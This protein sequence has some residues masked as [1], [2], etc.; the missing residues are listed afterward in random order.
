MDPLDE[1]MTYELL[2]GV[3]QYPLHRRADHQNT[4]R[5]VQDCKHVMGIPEEPGQ[6]SVRFHG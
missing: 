4:P 2:H 1:P 3:A 5:A 6:L